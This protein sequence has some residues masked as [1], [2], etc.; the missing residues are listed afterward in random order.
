MDEGKPNF[1]FLLSIY[2]AIMKKIWIVS[3]YYYPIVTSTGY[4]ITEIAEYLA[5]KGLN[6]HV[7]CTSAKYNETD[8]YRLLKIEKHN[9]VTIHRVLSGNIDKNNFVKRTFRLFNSSLCLW[10][11]ILGNIKREDELLVVTNPAFLLLF[12]P[13]IKNIKRI[14]YHLLV[15]DIFP[16]NLVAIGKLRS[17][18]LVY[19][20]LKSLFDWAYS[21][22]DSCISIGRDMAQIIQSKICKDMAITLISNWSD[23]KEVYPLDKKETKTYADLQCS[24]QFLFQ[25][26][27]NLGHAQ[28][29]DNILDAI[30]LIDNQDIHF[31]FIGGGA[32]YNIIKEFSSDRSNISLLGFQ[33]RS[34]Q[35]D[36]LNS[37]DI[38]IVTLSD[39]MYGLGV[40]SK[41][42]NIMAAGKPILYI[43]HEKSEIALCIKEYSLGWVVKPNDPLSLKLTIESI[44]NDRDVLSSIRNNARVVANTI[45]AKDN[46]LE[47]YYTLFA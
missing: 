42:Y 14:R 10:F 46:I 21:Q 23:N 38:G 4:Y 27:G 43:G 45:F 8:E 7:I 3:E 20:C 6:V 25:F 12:I 34:T 19:R 16:E 36:F 32:K 2:F 13:W 37:C 31:L 17:S 24:N 29:L 22:A 28:G 15:H 26:A 1:V 9:G 47:K 40:P 11:K 30:S 41:S 35:N 44:Y 39:G 5:N 33:S 18:S